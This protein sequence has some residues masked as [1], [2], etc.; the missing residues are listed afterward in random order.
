MMLHGTSFKNLN[1]KIIIWDS[2][3]SKVIQKFEK[4][5]ECLKQILIENK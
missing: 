1:D 4:L 2:I 5:Q 3:R